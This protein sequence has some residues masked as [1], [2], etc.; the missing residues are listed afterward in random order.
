MRTFFQK[1]NHVEAVLDDKLNAVVVRWF[2]LSDGDLVMECTLAQLE[3]VKKGAKV[4]I[5]DTSRASTVL[6]QKVQDWFGRVLFPR[7]RDAGLRA[8]ITVLSPY[9][10]TRL[11]AARWNMLGAPLGLET[12]ETG[13]LAA[14][15]KLAKKLKD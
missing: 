12:Y 6:D 9:A 13:S 3:E 14:A 5:A 10:L 8:I 2:D 7:L 15:R 1:P 11:S 4:I